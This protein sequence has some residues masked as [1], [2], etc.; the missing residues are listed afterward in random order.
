MAAKQGPTE[1]ETDKEQPYSAGRQIALG[2]YLI[3]ETLVV[4]LIWA[5]W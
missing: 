2:V 1:P 3:I 4:Y 5:N